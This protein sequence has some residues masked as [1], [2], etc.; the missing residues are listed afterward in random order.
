M[1]VAVYLIGT[2]IILTPVL[3]VSGQD[4][5]MAGLL[6]W[7]AG[8]V[9]ILFLGYCGPPEGRLLPVRLVLSL[10]SLHLAAMVTRNLGEILNLTMMP[11]TPQVV[12]SILLVLLAAY[13]TSEGI[14]VISRLA[15]LFLGA[16]I[17]TTVS[18]L[19]LAVPEM[20][21]EHLQ[22]VF[23]HSPGLIIKDSISFISFPF[24][25]VVVFL[26][27]LKLAGNHR[28]ALAGGALVAGA[29]LLISI[30]SIILLLP[31]AQIKDYISPAFEGVNFLAGSNIVKGALILIWL[32]TGFLKLAV[33]HY[34][35]TKQ[36]GEALSLDHRRIM[37]PISVLI[38]TFSIFLYSNIT[39]MFDFAFKI[40]PYYAM[41]LQLGI[42]LY[43]LIAGLFT[44]KASPA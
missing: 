23:E 1:T 26:P 5:W 27:L 16:F 30:L 40:Y 6:G 36:L 19:A 28:K 25:E 38:I 12:F 35:A 4:M 24:M 14:E 20:H 44:K 41:P 21:P 22:P 31:P 15:Y 8:T 33:L 37:A 43:I 2:A 29:L 32:Q 9:Y 10:Y 3:G 13:S 18:L 39:E 11:R 34:V 7:A 17:L 42:P